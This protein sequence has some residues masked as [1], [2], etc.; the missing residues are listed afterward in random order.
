LF[1]AE[2][3]NPALQA[4]GK[5]P[6]SLPCVASIN[7][8]NWPFMKAVV[9]L[10][11]WL[12]SAAR[13]GLGRYADLVVEDPPGAAIP[14]EGVRITYVGT[15]GYLLESGGTKLAVDPYFTR[16]GLFDVA[17]DRRQGPS[18]ESLRW[19]RARLPRHVDAILVTHGHFDHLLDVPPLSRALGARIIAS[20]TSTFLARAA[21]AERAMPARAGMRFTVGSAKIRVLQA[22]HDCVLGRVPFPG[23]RAEVPA[24]P[25]RPSDW[26]CGEP[27]AFLI[28]FGGQ[29]IYIDSGGTPAV[30]P[31]EQL[32]PID[33]AILGVALPD[34]RARLPAALERL[35]PR[36]VL[37]SHQ[38]HFFRPV[39][40]GFIF[41]PLTDFAEVRRLTAGQRLILLDY[42]HP[43]TLR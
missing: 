41:G 25:E 33:L 16:W 23:T 18:E 11:L 15:N 2:T 31:P 13:G 1:R 28:E 21:G 30:L 12:A 29:K 20:R 10:L 37:P 42:F 34:S 22:S 36:F 17:L 24:A 43:W 39:Q 19:A 4:H 9:L 32:G 3:A 5:Q 38:D 7:A 14:R 6:N 27:L 40:D 26:V 8:K 35:R